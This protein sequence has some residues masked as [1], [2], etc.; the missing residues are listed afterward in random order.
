MPRALLVTTRCDESELA[1]D[2]KPA[3]ALAYLSQDRATL[4]SACLIKA[5]R[6]VR[7]HD[8]KPAIPVLTEY[9]DFRMPSP[10]VPYNPL[11]QQ[12]TGGF[13]PAADAL[14]RLGSAAV[15]ALN[16]AVSSDDL[17]KIERVNAAKALFFAG[18]SKLQAIRS[19][20]TAAQSSKDPDAADALRKLAHDMV[21]YCQPSDR[22]QCQDAANAQ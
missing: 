21:R 16:A 3:V 18:A 9:L 8:Y 11:T 2:A 19:T 15:P 22:K 5:I 7:E 10:F 17:S 6:N 12:P 14:A 4:S 1:D 13:Y 20:A